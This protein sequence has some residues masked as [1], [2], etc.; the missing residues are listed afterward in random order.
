M[1]EGGAHGYLKKLLLNMRKARQIAGISASELE[2]RLILGPGWVNRFEE[3]ETVP[4]I[5]MLLAILHEVGADLNSL[6]MGL[7]ESPDAAE[8]ER[9]IFSEQTGKDIVIH[10][11]YANFDASYLLEK[12]KVEEFEVVVKT[13]RDGLAWLAKEE[14]SSK[15]IKADAVAKA[16]LKGVVVWPHAN[17]SDLWLFVVDRAY[18]DP[19]NHPAQFARLDFP[20]S[21]KRTG[22]WAL[23][24]VLVRHYGP[25]L[26]KHDIKLFIGDRTTKEK[27]LK[28]IKVK[29]RLE[30]DKIDVLLLG[31]ERE[32][33]FGV[34][35]V[36][37]SFAERRT[38]DVPMSVALAAAGYTTPLWTM[39]CKSMP[40]ANPHNKGEL[41]VVDGQRSAKRR[42]IED[43]G[44]F[45]GCFSYNRNTIAS[46][47]QLPEER[48]IYV[49]DFKNPQDVFS[50]FII[51][52]WR[53]FQR[54]A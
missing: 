12:A 52:R 32:E 6:L 25:Y 46:S 14:G 40:S 45:T 10:F 41:G 26:K 8:V 19:Y 47:K 21:W 22:G 43:E 34:V 54:R 7:P 33:F 5:D 44:Y 50:Q 15:A 35:H 38:D 53:N 18:C 23:E 20:Q 37:A 36:K 48:R 51:R 4:S 27:I 42:D 29:E 13:L 9:V 31:G 17:P 3:G 24:E 49:C 30:A 11:R 1:S 2:E 28:K 39:D 16:F